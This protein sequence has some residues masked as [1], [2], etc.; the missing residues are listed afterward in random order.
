MGILTSRRR[1]GPKTFFLL[2][3]FII[4][5]FLFWSPFHKFNSG[6]RSKDPKEAP[7]RSQYWNPLANGHSHQKHVKSSVD[8]HR[9][10]PDGL[11]EVNLAG[12]H[13][14][15]ELV[16]KAKNKWNERLLKASKTL[17]EAVAEYER[18]YQRRPPK[19]F[20]LW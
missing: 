18:R 14:I 6:P 12:S 11:L 10:R 15:Y 1:K 5:V 20:D 3:I 16:A 17:E 7:N 2:V 19:G 9:Y 4:I 13:P 8:K